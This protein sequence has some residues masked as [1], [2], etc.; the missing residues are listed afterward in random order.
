MAA[1]IRWF[2]IVAAQRDSDPKL[3]FQTLVR[4]HFRGAVK[5]PFNDSARRQAG[6]T[7]DYYTALAH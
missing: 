2:E 3:T 4:R 5:P 6:L 1:G 7:Q